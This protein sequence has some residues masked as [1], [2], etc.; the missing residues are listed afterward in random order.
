[1]AWKRS[2]RARLAFALTERVGRCRFD[3]AG[4]IDSRDRVKQGILAKPCGGS[5][6]TDV[7]VHGWT[8][9]GAIVS[10]SAIPYRCGAQERE[11][12]TRSVSSGTGG[13]SGGWRSAG[14]RR[15]ARTVPE[16]PSVPSTVRSTGSQ[17]AW[18]AIGSA[19]SCWDR[20]V[21]IA[22]QDSKDPPNSLP[23]AGMSHARTEG[24]NVPIGPILP[25]LIPMPLQDESKPG[26]P[27]PGLIEGVPAED[28]GYR[29]YLGDGTG[30]CEECKTGKH[31]S[32]LLPRRARHRDKG[33]QLV[34]PQEA[35]E[36]ELGAERRHVDLSRLAFWRRDKTA[37]PERPEAYTG[38]S[39]AQEGLMA[40]L[41]EPKRASP[42]IE[43]APADAERGPAEPRPGLLSRVFQSHAKADEPAE[44]SEHSEDAPK[45]PD[46]SAKQSP[47]TRL[48]SVFQ[49]HPDPATTVEPASLPEDLQVDP[50]D[51]TPWVRNLPPRRAALARTEPKGTSSAPVRVVQHVSP[52]VR[53][54]APLAEPTLRPTEP[55]RPAIGPVRAPIA[56]VKLRRDEQTATY[57]RAPQPQRAAAATRTAATTSRPRPNRPGPVWGPPASPYPCAPPPLDCPPTPCC[58][59]LPCCP[60]PWDAFLF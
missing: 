12:E 3:I 14:E 26:N 22:S 55:I 38:D 11:T 58:D 31:N 42:R 35:I 32:R 45:R 16:G 28:R 46:A 2:S 36:R 54:D 37:D 13:M 15:N 21:R 19:Q 24:S 48:M 34:M 8:L 6:G 9:L 53:T 33:P 41:H 59:P 25:R 39:T 52:P 43:S 57:S 40:R 10:V 5:G 44:P 30:E 50:P 17:D 27:A 18:N 56:P 51:P 49:R 20:A 7:N 4:T 60:P 1:M 29:T 47:T 23:R